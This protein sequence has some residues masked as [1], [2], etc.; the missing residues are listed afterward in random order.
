MRLIAVTLE[1]SQY[2]WRVADA[3]SRSRTRRSF[4]FPRTG[5]LSD[6]E[7]LPERHPPW[8]LAGAGR[9]R[10]QE[11]AFEIDDSSPKERDL[12][13]KCARGEPPGFVRRGRV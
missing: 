7:I 3:L 12:F 10:R 11:A 6:I 9:R 13:F 4:S 5:R 8:T 1:A 2:A